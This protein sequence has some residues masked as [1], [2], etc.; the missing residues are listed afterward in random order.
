MRVYISQG[1]IDPGPGA[2]GGSFTGI[3]YAPDSDFMSDGCKANWD[4]A[5]VVKTYTC[6]GGPNQDFKYDTRAAQLVQQF[7]N[8]PQDYTEIPSSQVVLP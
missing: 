3:L 6:N 4:G 7:W 8:P 2:N 5:I 1:S